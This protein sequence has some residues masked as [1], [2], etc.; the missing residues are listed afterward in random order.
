MM[1][2]LLKLSRASQPANMTDRP[3]P[4]ASI[5]MTETGEAGDRMVTRDTVTF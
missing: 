1:S 3:L 2:V 5:E 4:Q